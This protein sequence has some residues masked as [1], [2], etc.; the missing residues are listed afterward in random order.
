MLIELFYA[1]FSLVSLQLNPSL[2]MF[3]KLVRYVYLFQHSWNLSEYPQSLVS[4]CDFSHHTSWN[5]P[6]TSWPCN[7]WY[8]INF[9][10]FYEWWIR[11]WNGVYKTAWKFFMTFPG[12]MS[13]NQFHF[14]FFG[15]CE[16]SCFHY[17]VNI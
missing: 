5:L 4:G 17:W 8:D 12:L 10:P 9:F 2:K 13:L 6:R 15:S 3:C 1:L 16:C 7:H 14:S 11:Q